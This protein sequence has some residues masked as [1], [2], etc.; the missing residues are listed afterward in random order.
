MDLEK[1]IDPTM[2]VFIGFKWCTIAAFVILPKPYVCKKSGSQVIN[3]NALSQ[4]VCRIF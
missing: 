4:P 3:E 2:C 1:K